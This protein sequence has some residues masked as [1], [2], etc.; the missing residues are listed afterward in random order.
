MAYTEYRPHPALRPY[1]EAYW[2]VSPDQQPAQ[3]SHRILPDG[4]ADLIFTS[5]E[6]SFLVGMM[7]VYKDT[8]SKPGIALTGIRFRAGGMNVFYPQLQHELTDLTVPYKDDQLARLIWSAKDL[9]AAVDHYYLQKIPLRP[10]DIAAITHDI[11][12]A[13]GNINMDGLLNQYYMSERKLERLF[14]K[15]VGISVKGYSKIIR[16]V[17]T[18]KL[19]QDV[20]R[21]KSMVQIAIEAGYYDQAHFCNEIKKYAGSTPAMLSFQN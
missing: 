2:T 9:P 14:K 20:Q 7:T 10:T 8:L 19:L 17:H 13:K 11:R 4:C 16:F 18:L 6:H 3:H 12:T 1:I 5:E 21:S 15:E